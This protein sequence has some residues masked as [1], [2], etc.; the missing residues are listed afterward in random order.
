MNRFAKYSLFLIALYM[1][2]RTI[3]N[4]FFYDQFPIALLASEFDQDQMEAYRARVIIPAY[5]LTCIYFLGRYFSGK[6]ST[7]TVWPLYV[8][9][10]CLLV[11]HI[12]GFITFMPFSKD[13]I[14]MFVGTL[15]AFFVTRKAHNQRKN[16]IF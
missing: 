8:A 4:L 9:S 11:T 15:W 14:T 5:F 1:L 16:E 10:V 2:F 12:I 7:S 6:S 3:I 13:P